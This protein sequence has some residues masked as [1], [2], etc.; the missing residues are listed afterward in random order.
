[1]NRDPNAKLVLLKTAPFARFKN[2]VEALNLCQGHKSVRQL[3][4]VTDS[5]QSMVLEFLDK[6]LYEA[7]CEQ[8]L[9]RQDIKRAGKAAL[10]DVK[11]NNFLVNL[12]SGKSRFNEI[13]LG[14]LGD[15]VP[16]DVS[17]NTGQHMIGAPIYRAPEVMLNVRWTTAVDIWSLGATVSL[18]VTTLNVSLY[19]MKLT[20]YLLRRHI[21]VPDEVK[22]D[23]DRFPFL[24]LMLQIK[25]FGPFP[26]KFFQL[27][28]DEAAQVLRYISEQ[29]NGTTNMFSQ[30][31]SET[32]NPEDRDFICYLM[33]P[34]PRDRPSS[35]EALAHPWL[36]DVC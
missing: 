23:D 6:N 3:L 4:D 27:L 12:G 10:E 33:R 16:E 36:K 20:C 31:N 2:E 5:P 28:D 24:I 22:P 25:Y 13:K 32:I 26:E 7:S 15:S 14:D 8:Q 11:P 30:A 18:F 34:D 17:T 21:F 29:C 35:K 19:A 9:N 1:M